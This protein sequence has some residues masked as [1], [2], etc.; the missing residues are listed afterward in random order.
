MIEI[1]QEAIEEASFCENKQTQN[2]QSRI[3]KPGIQYLGQHGMEPAPM[4][5]QDDSNNGSKSNEQRNV[6]MA[7]AFYILAGLLLA[8]LDTI[9]DMQTVHAAFLRLGWWLNEWRSFPIP[10]DLEEYTSQ[11]L[12]DAF[13]LSFVPAF[14]T[15]ILTHSIA[16]AVLHSMTF[17]IVALVHARFGWP[18]YWGD[19]RS[20][21]DLRAEWA[22]SAI[23]SWWAWPVAQFI[24][25]LLFQIGDGYRLAFYP[26]IDNGPLF[27]FANVIAACL[28]VGMITN[29]ILRASVIQAVGSGEFRCFACGYLLRG[30]THHRCPE[31]GFSVGGEGEK[32]YGVLRLTRLQPL[33]K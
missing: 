1:R 15:M 32:E 8:A 31:C 23:R 21:L 30:L 33:K 13:S 29:R 19:I 22:H 27:L 2:E 6:L 12:G 3:G 17:S 14:I 7:C 24:W 18:K 4:P 26:I 9:S 11:S 25:L 10:I 28:M 5:D 16:T 20:R